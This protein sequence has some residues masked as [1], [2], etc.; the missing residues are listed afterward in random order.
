MRC[1]HSG[2]GHIMTLFP[3]P[4]LLSLHTHPLLRAAA[5]QMRAA[6]RYSRTRG[7]PRAGPRRPAAVLAPVPQAAGASYMPAA[8]RTSHPHGVKLL[9]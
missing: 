1:G 9:A 8:A 7:A 6:W 2:N 5:F 4:Q 3:R